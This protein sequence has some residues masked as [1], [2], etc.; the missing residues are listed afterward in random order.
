MAKL[1]SFQDA[2]QQTEGEKRH[3]VLGNGFSIACR[4]DIFC[5]DTLFEQADFTN[6]SQAKELFDILGTRDFEEVINTLEKSSQIIPIYDKSLQRLVNSLTVDAKTI[7]H[8][9]VDTVASNHPSRPN[10]ILDKEFW[11]CRKF[12]SHFLDK[13]SCKRCSVYSL[14]YDL[15]LYWVLMHK[16]EK[17]PFNFT[18]DDGFNRDLEELR[19]DGEAELSPDVTWQGATQSHRQNIHFLHGALHLYDE[20]SQLRKYTWIDTGVVLTGQ[21][22]YSIEKGFFPLFVSEGTSEKKMDKILHSA[23]LHKCYRS[24]VANTNIKSANFYT[25]GYSFSSNDDH[26]SRRFEE[27]KFKNLYVGLYGN[28][29]DKANQLIVQKIEALKAARP[30]RYPLEVSYYDASTANVWGLDICTI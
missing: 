3:L 24:L 16:K 4:P 1:I 27:G 12:L 8:L 21:A 13:D 28:I 22:R 19:A 20:G 10:N 14:N 9:L 2:I 5:Y 25:Y 23:Y 7:K 30:S 29:G 11:A 26:I 17:D 6:S 15:L 18:F